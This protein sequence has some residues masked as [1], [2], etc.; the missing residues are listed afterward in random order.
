MNADGVGG[1]RG[2]LSH[3]GVDVGEDGG[4]LGGELLVLFPLQERSGHLGEQANLCVCVRAC[5]RACVCVWC[6][7]VCACV[8]GV[9]VCVRVCVCGVCVCVCVRVCVCG[10]CVCVCVCVCMRVCACTHGEWGLHVHVCLSVCVYQ[11]T[12]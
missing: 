11:A 12:H 1:G 7:C 5:V 10:V 8:C 3:R 2:I 9:C 6:V 4:D